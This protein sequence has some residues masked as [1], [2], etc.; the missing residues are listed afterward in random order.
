MM[1]MFSTRF[2]LRKQVTQSF[3]TYSSSDTNIFSILIDY[4]LCVMQC[5]PPYPHSSKS[6]VLFLSIHEK[7]QM[8][9]LI[10]LIMYMYIEDAYGQSILQSSV[11]R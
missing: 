1:K 7:Y 9:C 4:M 2:C 8:L 5:L 6:F 3:T 11:C 10:I